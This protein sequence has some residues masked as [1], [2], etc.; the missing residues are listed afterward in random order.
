MSFADIA[1]VYDI[2]AECY[3]FQRIPDSIH[4]FSRRR[5]PNRHMEFELRMISIYTANYI[6]S[7]FIMQTIHIMD[8][9]L[10]PETRI[11]PLADGFSYEQ[12]IMVKTE[13]FRLFEQQYGDR[14][15]Y[16]VIGERP[17]PEVHY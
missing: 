8:D 6:Y 15:A 2:Y 4:L 3:R 10:R 12:Y 16:L 17:K 1:R 11:T 7:P 5:N 14:I 9:I 13:V